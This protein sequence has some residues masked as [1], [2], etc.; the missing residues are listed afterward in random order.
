MRDDP[1]IGRHVRDGIFA[2]NKSAIGKPA[3]Q[4]TIQST[5]FVDVAIYGVGNLL[6]GILHEVMVLAGHRT[7]A[8]HLPEQPLHH[9][10]TLAQVERKEFS[11]FLG[12]VRKDGTGFEYADRC[13][14]AG[15]LKIDDCGDPVV[16]RYL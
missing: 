3:I 2:A 5:C 16:R 1:R 4:H 12:Q 9:L 7:Q 10:D 6:R 14:A 15:R 11:C 13:T 8:T